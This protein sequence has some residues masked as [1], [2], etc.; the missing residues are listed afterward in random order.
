MHCTQFALSCCLLGFIS[1]SSHQS[2]VAHCCCCSNRSRRFGQYK[3]N[4]LRRFYS[5][6]SS[7]CECTVKVISAVGTRQKEDIMLS[8]QKVRL[9]LWQN[10]GVNIRSFCL[11][12]SKYSIVTFWFFFFFFGLQNSCPKWSFLWVKTFNRVT[13][14]KG[15]SVNLKTC[16]TAQR[17][18]YFNIWYWFFITR[19]PLFISI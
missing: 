3:V 9:M 6:S 8:V 18:D 12:W 19:L 16:K 7:W 11:F 14:R 1:R 10:F 17:G 2:F 15:S 13:P 5:S 4:Y